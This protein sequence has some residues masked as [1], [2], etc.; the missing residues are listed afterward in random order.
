MSLCAFTGCGRSVYYGRLCKGH[1]QQR[2]RGGQLVPLQERRGW[3]VR[4][5][6]DLVAALARAEARAA[7]RRQREAAVPE[8]CNPIPA[9]PGAVRA[10]SCAGYTACLDYAERAGWS[11]FGCASCSKATRELEV[12]AAELVRIT[13][14]RSAV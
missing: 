14:R 1:V 7:K 13:Q 3:R 4:T 2:A 12:R 10:F 9:A 11:G 8:G 6:Y 5:E